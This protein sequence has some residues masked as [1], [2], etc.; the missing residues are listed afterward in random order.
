MSVAIPERVRSTL[1]EITADPAMN[2]GML[3]MERRQKEFDSTLAAQLTGIFLNPLARAKMDLALDIGWQQ[4]PIPKSA[5]EVIVGGGLHAAIY[6]AVRVKMGHP[7]P[8][9]I[10]AKDRA[11]GV[12]AVS[13]EP[14]FYLNSRNRPGG[15]GIPGREESL[16]FLPGALIQP[17]DLSGDEYQTNATL[18]YSIRMTIALCADV[19]SGYKVVESD[20][21]SVTLDNGK[22]ILTPRV[23]YATGLGESTGPAE[24]DGK[25]M[26]D[27]MQF[28][29]MLD[30]PFPFE[31]IKRVAV[32]GAGDSGKTVI[33]ALIGQGPNRGLSVASLDYVEK[34]DWYGVPEECRGQKRWRDNNRSR[35][36]G[37]SRSFG[38]RGEEAR[39]E[40]GR[41]NPISD[42]S[43]EYATGFDGAY[44]D[45]ARYDL[46][47]WAGGFKPLDVAGSVEFR[48]GGRAVCRRNMDGSFIVGPAAQLTMEN[49]RQN[50]SRSVPENT[51]ALFRYADRTAALA[52]A[53]PDLGMP[54]RGLVV[55]PN[56]DE[57]VILEP[58]NTS[59]S[60]T[61]VDEVSRLKEIVARERTVKG[62]D[63]KPYRVGDLIAS[64]DV[65]RGGNYRNEQRGKVLSITGTKERPVVK[66]RSSQGYSRFT[67][68]I[69][70]PK[71]WQKVERGK[72]IDGRPVSNY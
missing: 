10:E 19:V 17:A 32:I 33:E 11:G 59:I 5:P 69:E 70:K 48:C 18:A 61:L 36:Q 4:S 23:I 34:I 57:S 68:V 45:G 24:M 46:V 41:V 39:M 63:G 28:F 54:T 22:V 13:S 72:Q 3:A 35:Y 62:K 71:V 49:E 44:V 9:I 27:A 50:D 37:I 56:P 60:F 52:M 47:V 7:K 8:L 40:G 64:K 55:P 31:G 2:N 12:F 26:M 53:L 65:S 67:S 58:F 6:S 25:H 30:K 20:A 51:V 66:I 21:T 15:P 14:S 1:Q 42:K 38:K 16:N 29:A 43:V